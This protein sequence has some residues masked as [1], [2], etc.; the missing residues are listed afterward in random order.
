[1]KADGRSQLFVRRKVTQTCI[2]LG[3]QQKEA[4]AIADKV[5][6]KIYDGIPTKRILSMIFKYI[7]K[8]QPAVKHQICLRKALSLI[9]PK[10]DFE[11]YVQL[12]LE[13]NDYEVYP[14]KIIR[15]KCVEHEVDAVAVKDGLT[16]IVEVKHKYNYHTPVSLDISRIARA[17]FEDLVE[18]Y[19]L[20]RNDIK[21]DKALIVCNTKLSDHAIEYSKCREIDHICWSSPKDFD[22]QTMIERKK[23]FPIT[24]I[25]GLTKVNKERLSSAGIILLK[26]LSEVSPNAIR[27]QTGIRRKTV[28][29]LISKAEIL[30]AQ[31]KQCFID[32]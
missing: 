7:R 19:E 1:M 6:K 14:N 24:H 12:L 4:E 16:Y 10:P 21:V 29:S 9:E 28:E 11:R 32:L 18:G 15:G 30:L 25:R 8:D 20:G 13:E 23:L 2:R 26:Q 5:E 22:L 31:K 3:A 17:V 27:E